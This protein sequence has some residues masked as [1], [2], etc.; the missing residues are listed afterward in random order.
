[1]VTRS[2]W[3]RKWRPICRAACEP[4]IARRHPF[5]AVQSVT[6]IHT[7]VVASGLIGQ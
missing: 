1:M 4:G 5:S 7:E 6:A 2:L 3:S